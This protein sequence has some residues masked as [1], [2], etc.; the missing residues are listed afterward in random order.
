MKKTSVSHLTSVHARYDVRVFQKMCRSLA[1]HEFNVNL[2]VADG[3]GNEI[4]GNV[5]IIDAGPK[6]NWRPLRM[7]QSVNQVFR[8]AV[9]LDSDIYHLHD[10]ELIPIGVKLKALG[11]TVIF[12]SH[13]DYASDILAKHYIPEVMRK[14]IAKIYSWYE[15]HALSKYDAIVTATPFIRDKF[16]GFGFFNVVDINNYPLQDELISSEGASSE[17]EFD[18]VFMGAITSPRGIK[19]VVQSLPICGARLA[20]AGIFNTPVF[21]A[22][23]ETLEGWKNVTYLGQV[24]KK[25]VLELLAKSRIGIVTYLPYPNH[26]DSQPNKL[27]EYMDFGLPVISSDFKLWKDIVSVNNCGVCVDPSNPKAIADAISYL[28]KNPDEAAVMGVNGQ[29]MVKEKYNWPN[30]E[31][32][33]LKFYRG[34]IA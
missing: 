33:L 12:D 20:L 31:A 2:V 9:E 32:S 10:P 14:P 30:E 1:K 26:I 15:Q 4:I 18:A 17:K 23:L 34:L 6:P 7:I 3:L 22:E 19:E 5:N 13:E 25:D 16:R 21:K 27:F 11:K 8:K 29:R 24:S 28:L